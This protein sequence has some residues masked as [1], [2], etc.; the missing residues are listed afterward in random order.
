M[1]FLRLCFFIL[2]FIESTY[3]QTL[4]GTITDENGIVPF[5]DIYLKVKNEI[6]QKGVANENGQYKFV[7]ISPSDSL[8]IIASSPNHEVKKV[9]LKHYLHSKNIIEIDIK[10]EKKNNAFKRSCY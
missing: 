6:K 8:Y 5:A 4:K 3:S 2:V 1:N 7:L 9:L 10:L